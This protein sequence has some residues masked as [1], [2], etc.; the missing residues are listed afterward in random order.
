[1]SSTS[2]NVSA[3]PEADVVELLLPQVRKFLAREV[4]AE[5]IDR[6][7][8]IPAAVRE[9][10]A[11][12][13][14]FG[15]TIPTEYGG[16]GLPL[17]SA[18]RVVTE[19][20]RVDRSIA[21]MIGLH[22]GLGTRGL[23]A[24]GSPELRSTWLPRL[25]SGECVASFSVTEANAGSDLTAIRTT[26][27]PTREGLR[28]V[29]EKSYVTNGGFA[30]LFTVLVRTP[31][32][33]GERATSVVCIPRDTPGVEIGLEEDK[34]G[35][36]GSSTVTLTFDGAVVPWT[37]LIGEAGRGMD[38]AHELLGWGRTLMSAGCVGTA[39]A[40]LDATVA[41]VGMRRQFGRAIGEFGATRVHVAWMAARVHAMEAIMKSV[42]DEQA[43]GRNIETSSAIAKV[44]TSE[45]AFAVCDRAV[46][47][48]GA[49]G[50]LEPTGVARMLRDSRITRIFEGANDVLLVRIGA[51]RVTSSAPIVQFDDSPSVRALARRLDDAVA[52]IR[53]RLGIRAVRRQLLLQRIASA[54]ISVTVA[55]AAALSG[56]PLGHYAS[57]QLVE[58]G[59][60]ALDR[61]VRAERDEDEA[62]AL[63]ESR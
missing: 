33:G 61:L 62:T 59:H 26:A 2:V 50:F 14:L 29:G 16:A 12:L 52:E 17:G 20:A 31:G 63:F 22:V 51:A 36:R 38:V 24:Y 23:V 58:E 46:Q 25:A 42:A 53:S 40:A 37:N 60:H 30:G 45:S 49:L 5:A 11:G 54:E 39:R 34:L 48:H 32:I 1:M 57:E 18:C 44:F 56:G 19:L 41:Y 10:A 27:E 7:G 43:R 8:L 47:L 15:L 55:R 28:I 21:I 35:V 9:S 13:G 3:A 6:E 4:R